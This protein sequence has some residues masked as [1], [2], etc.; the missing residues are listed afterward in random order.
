MDVNE[1][2]RLSSITLK[3]N[4]KHFHSSS[5]FHSHSRVFN[6]VGV[7][8]INV[9]KFKLHVTMMM[10]KKMVVLKTYI[11]SFINSSDLKCCIV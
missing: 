11:D 4:L 2:E 1:H 3:H 8:S 9:I 10:Q 7:L 5:T 6:N